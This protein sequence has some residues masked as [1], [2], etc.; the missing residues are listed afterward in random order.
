MRL[1]ERRPA[2]V[3]P[4][5]QRALVVGGRLIETRAHLVRAS[6]IRVAELSCEGNVGVARRRS[7][8]RGSG[9]IDVAEQLLALSDTNGGHPGI[10][11]RRIGGEIGGES[12]SRRG[13]IALRIVERRQR[14]DG[15]PRVHAVAARRRHNQRV[16]RLVEHGRALGCRRA[17]QAIHVKGAAQIACA[18]RVNPF[19]IRQRALDTSDTIVLAGEQIE[20]G[21]VDCR[22]ESRRRFA[23]LRQAE[24]R[25]DEVH[26]SRHE[27]LD[28]N[29]GNR[30]LE[31]RLESQLETKPMRPGRPLAWRVTP[32]LQILDNRKDLQHLLGWINTTALEIRRELECLFEPRLRC[33]RC[34][35]VLA[36]DLVERRDPGRPVVG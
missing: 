18:Q 25:L 22:S 16:A 8:E 30:L 27:T 5:F 24:M 11:G 33:R 20:D 23:Q 15:P 7:P 9:R 3:A 28:V 36:N 2:A 12:G 10:R 13:E 29:R 32:A 14:R 21:S 26:E 17:S 1:H 34:R 35:G 4:L 19:E 6:C 31:I